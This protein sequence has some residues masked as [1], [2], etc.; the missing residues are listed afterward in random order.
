MELGGTTIKKYLNCGDIKFNGDYLE[1]FE[2][3]V[4][5]SNSLSDKR[6]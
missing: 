5:K 1:R 2:K 3:Y 4:K 6:L